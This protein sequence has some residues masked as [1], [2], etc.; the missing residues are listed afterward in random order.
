MHDDS[1]NA[2]G[3]FT[4]EE[5]TVIYVYQPLNGTIK[6]IKEDK[7]NSAL[8]LAGAKFNVI[9]S[10]EVVVAELETDG[11]GEAISN[12]LP[13]GEYTLV[14][15]VAPTGYVLST[16]NLL[17][18]VEPGTQT[19]KVIK[20]KK[21]KGSLT[22]T[23]IDAENGKP[24]KGGTFEL[25]DADHNS[26]GIETSGDD[27]KLT[28]TG[29]EWGIYTLVETKA[30]KG[31]RLLENKISIEIKADELQVEITVENTKQDWEIP[32]TG[33]IGTVGFYGVGLILM[34]SAAWFVFRRR[35][36]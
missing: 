22:V 35:P 14:E 3:I 17:V 26:V 31:Y 27:G 24:L 7:D 15:V 32:D 8:K 19:T 16:T 12:P 28:F 29:L 9:N 6:I 4:D 2:A 10:E 5:Q 21:N 11:N 13:V 25:F 1:A 18:T 36:V 23:K 33:G 34:L 20:N 30:P